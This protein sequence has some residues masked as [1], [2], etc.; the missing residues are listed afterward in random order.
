MEENSLKASLF[1]EYY[2]YPNEDEKIFNKS[3]CMALYTY[4]A[5]QSNFG[6]IDLVNL[7]PLFN[8][9]ENNIIKFLNDII[10]KKTS[11]KMLMSLKS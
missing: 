1:F 4:N 3:L 10:D 2:F 7:C 8:Q 9:I 6:G 5:F 11:I